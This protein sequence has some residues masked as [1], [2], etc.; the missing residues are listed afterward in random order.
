[1]PE[2]KIRKYPLLG[3]CELIRCKHSRNSGILGSCQTTATLSP[4]AIHTSVQQGP[5]GRQT[6]VRDQEGKL[7]VALSL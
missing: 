3:I 4:S 2:A 5:F 1:M 7:K 6:H